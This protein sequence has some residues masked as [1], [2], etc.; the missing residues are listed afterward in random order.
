[1]KVRRKIIEEVVLVPA[2]TTKIDILVD[3]RVVWTYTTP[4]EPKRRVSILITI[5]EYPYGAEVA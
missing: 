1:M 4:S 3:D 2:H 5:E